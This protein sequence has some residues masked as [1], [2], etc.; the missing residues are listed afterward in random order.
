MIQ[1]YIPNGA[2]QEEELDNEPIDTDICR[3]VFRGMLAGLQYLHW[4]GVVHRDIKPSNVLIDENNNAKLADF[5]TSALVPP[6]N[7]RLSDVQ[8]TP[9]F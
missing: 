1:E 6:D 8:G 2:I 7:D 3:L 4:Q 5:G 9:A